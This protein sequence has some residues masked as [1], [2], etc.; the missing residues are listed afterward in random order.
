MVVVE[1]DLLP[2][3]PAVVVI[4]LLKDYPAVKGLNPE[5]LHDGERLV[6]ATRL[7][8]A[9]RRT[10]LRRAGNVADQGDQINRAVDVLMAGV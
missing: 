5:I 8:A 4:P 3:D 9:V 1:S 6:L 7:I 10:S 2:P